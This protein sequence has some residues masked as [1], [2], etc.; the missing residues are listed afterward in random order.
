MLKG[1]G[2][3]IP[4]P[5]YIATGLVL[6][7][8]LPINPYGYYTFLRIVVTGIATLL[9][10]RAF[11]SDKHGWTWVMALTAA[12]YNPIFPVHLTREIWSGVNVATAAVFIFSIPHI[13]AS[14]ALKGERGENAE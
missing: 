13:R 11:S 9:A 12:A 3:G 7:A 2:R 10:V 8:L 14:I 4:Y 1:D 6:W 5:Q